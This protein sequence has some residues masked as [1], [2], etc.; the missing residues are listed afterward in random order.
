[1]CVAENQLLFWAFVP[2]GQDFT[3]SDAIP[4]YHHHIGSANQKTV[5]GFQGLP[6]LAYALQRDGVFS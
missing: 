6:E 2:E 1:M 4:W 3:E 5:G